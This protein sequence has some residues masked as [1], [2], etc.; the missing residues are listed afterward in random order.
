[1]C[2]GSAEGGRDDEAQIVNFLTTT[3]GGPFGDRANVLNQARWAALNALL[4]LRT[5]RPQFDRLV[6]ALT[7]TRSA[8]QPPSFGAAVL[9]IDRR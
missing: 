6:D 3:V 7:E 4:L 9:A 8:A 5:H 1:M 2:F